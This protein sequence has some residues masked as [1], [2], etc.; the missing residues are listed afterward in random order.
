MSQVIEY[1]ISI[2]LD[3]IIEWLG[4]LDARHVVHTSGWQVCEKCLV[5]RYLQQ[6]LGEP[7]ISVGYNEAFAPGKIIYIL[8]PWVGYVIRILD[9]FANTS[10]DGVLRAENAVNILKNIDR[11]AL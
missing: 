1:P 10:D 11:E 4:S 6:K 3:G 5:A 2:T 8:E 9:D 7:E